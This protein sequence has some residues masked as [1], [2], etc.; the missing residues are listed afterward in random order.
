MLPYHF[1]N[2]VIKDFESTA[3]K[4]GYEPY[5]ITTD[6]PYLYTRRVCTDKVP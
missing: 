6:T 3:K 4:K 2:N 5:N 1:T